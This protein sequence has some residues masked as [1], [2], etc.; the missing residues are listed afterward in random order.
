MC[1]ICQASRP[2]EEEDTCVS[3][4]AILVSGES[5]AGKVNFFYFY[6]EHILENTFVLLSCC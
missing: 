5:G 1:V 6:R 3:Y 2:G 4:V